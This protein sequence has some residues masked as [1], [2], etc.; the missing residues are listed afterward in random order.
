MNSSTL[1]D[2]TGLAAGTYTVT[3]TDVNG[4][5]A[6]VSQT[7]TAAAVLSV[8]VSSFT[9]IACNGGTTGTISITTTGGTTPYSYLWNNS[10]TLQDQTGLAVGT[11][12]V[13]V[14][15]V[16]GCTIT[17]S[18]IILSVSG[19]IIDL[20]ST[21]N[22]NC[23]GA[24]NGSI[25]ISV[26]GGTPPYLF[27]WSNGSSTEDITNIGVGLYLVT[28]S[29]IN[30]CTTTLQQ[31][32]S[33]PD[34]II[35]QLDTLINSPC[36]QVGSASIQIS[37]LGGT[38]PYSYLWSNGVTMQDIFSL[39]SGNYSVTVTDSIGCIQAV[40]YVV[41]QPPNLIGAITNV[42]NV[43]CNGQNNGSINVFVGGGAGGYTYNWSNGATN[44]NLTNVSAGTYT[45]SIKDVN[46]CSVTID[47][48][49]TEPLFLQIDLIN[50][51]DVTC[52]GGSNG[53]ITIQVSGGTSPY[54]YLW[55]NG[56]TTLSMTG[57][58]VGLYT[59]LVTDVNGC[60]KNFSESILQNDSLV[61]TFNST[62][63]I[64]NL[65]NGSIGVNVSG[66]TAPYTYLWSTGGTNDTVSNVPAGL[67][68]VSISDFDG[69]SKS[70]T[71]SLSNINGPSIVVDSINQ[72]LCNGP[73]NGSIYITCTSGT[74]PYTFLWSD[75]ST[76]EDLLNEQIGIYTVTV[77][78]AAGCISILTDSIQIDD[79]IEV[80]FNVTNAQCNL[81]NGSV[82]TSVTGGV[83][84]YGYLWSSGSTNSQLTN[85][86]AGTYTLT[87]TD[88]NGCIAIDSVQIGNA[89]SFSVQMNVIQNALCYGANT[90]AISC[91]P[92]GGVA[93]YS[94]LWSN[95]ITNQ[96]VVSLV[97][98]TYTV[99]VTDALGCTSSASETITEPTEIILSTSSINSLCGQANGSASVLAAGGVGPYQYNWSNGSTTNTTG[100]SG[101]GTYTVTVT[102]AINCSVSS[103]VVILNTNGP[104]ALVTGFTNNSCNS[105]SSGS[106][107][108]SV[109]G[110]APPYSVI[111]SNGTTT[112]N[113]NFIPSGTY[114]ATVTDTNNCSSVVVQTIIQ[115]DSINIVTS[116]NPAICTNDNGSITVSASG[117][118]G[119]LTFLWSTGASVQTLNGLS[120]GI[121]TVTVT[122]QN[123]CT[124]TTSI[125]VIYFPPPN[126]SIA[127]FTNISCYGFNN[128]VININVSSGTLPYTYLWSNGSTVANQ[129]NLAPGN[130]SVVVTDSLGCKDTATQFLTEPDSLYLLLA[131][132]NLTCGIQNGLVSVTAIGG[133]PLYTYLWSNNNTNA[134][135][136]GLAAGT[137]TVT[138]TDAKG[139][140]K[141]GS[142]TIVALSTPQLAVQ[143]QV[144][145]SCN[146]GNNGS[147]T[148]SVS[149]GQLAY[150]YLWST[151]G[152]T[153][154]LA[155]LIAGSYTVTV[156]DANGC[157]DTLIVNITQP[158]NLSVVL[159]KL[160]AICGSNNGQIT[161]S[162]SGGTTPYSFLWSNTAT[163][164]AINNLAAGTYTV[165]VTD[166]NGCTVISSVSLQQI[167][168]PVVTIQNIGSPSCNGG[169][170]GFININASGAGNLNFLW[171]NAA[172]TQNISLIT[173]GTYT[174]TVTDTNGCTSTL[175]QLIIEPALIDI[176]IAK[177]DVTCNAPN[178]VA[179]AS[180]S[181]G[182]GS[183]A[184]LWSNSNTT[185]TI[186]GLLPGVYTVTVTD[187]NLCSKT[188]SVTI[189]SLATPV[190]TFDSVKHV[191]C[192]GGSDGYASVFVTGGTSPYSYLW[193]NGST[194]SVANGLLAGLVLIT[195]TDAS[196]CSVYEDTLIIEPLPLSLGMNSTLVSCF[197][198]DGTASVNVSGGVSPYTYL[199]STGSTLNSI[200]GQ[201]TGTYTVTVTDGN[202]CLKSDT[203]NISKAP[204][205]VI[206]FNSVTGIGCTGNPVGAIDILVTGGI[207][208]TYLWSNAATTQD[209]SG[210]L[211]GLYTITVTNNYGCSS[212]D[213]IIVPGFYPISI[214]SNITNATC[215]N[216]NGSISSIVSGGS[217]AYFYLWS[218]NATTSAISGLP[219]GVYTVTVTDNQQCT[220]TTTFNLINLA[221]PG[222]VIDSI[223][224][225]LCAGDSNAAI[226]ISALGNGLLSYLWSNGNTLEDLIGVPAGTY[227]I[228]ISDSN[229]CQTDSTIIISQTLAMQIQFSVVPANCGLSNGA[230]SAAIING[231]QPYSYLWSTSSSSDTISSLSAGLFAL[232]VTDING[233]IISDTVSVPSLN[234]VL[235]IVDSIVQ[236]LCNGGSDGGVYL[237]VQSSSLFSY[238]W[239]GGATTEDLTGVAAGLYTLSITGPNGCSF[240][241]TFNIGQP[242]A[243]SA[244]FQL[245]ASA[246]SSAT[247]SATINVSGGT[248][249]YSYNWSNGATINSI[250]GVGSGTYTCTV[251][252]LNGCVFE[253]SI[254][255]GLLS[256][257]QVVT[258][259]I[260]N[261]KCYGESNGGIYI[262]ALNGIPLY[263][264]QW[265]NGA[266][267]Q[268]ITTL[269]A[270][271]YSVL[272]T[273][274]AGCK[275][276]AVFNITQP[277]S[278]SIALQ[279]VAPDCNTAN[280]SITAQSS[281]GT[282]G[283]TYLWD[284]GNTDAVLSNLAQGTYTVTV[285]DINGCSKSVSFN[286]F[287]V[288]APVIAVDSVIN[289]V[290]GGS[291]SGAIYITASGN[292]PFSYVWSNGSTL[293][294]LSGIAGGTYS[295]TVT[296]FAGCTSLI[297]ISV[298]ENPEIIL[299]P[300]SINAACGSS[301]GVAYVSAAGGITPY[302]YF[303]PFDN[304]TNDTLS[305]L[306]PGSYDVIIT[307]QL[308][309][310]KQTTVNVSNANAPVLSIDSIKHVSCAGGANGAIFVST[311]GG[312]QPYSYLWNNGNTNEDILNIPAGVYSLTIVDAL[313]CVMIISDTVFQPDS[314][315][316]SFTSTPAGCALPNGSATVIVNGGVPNY[317]YQWNVFSVT[318]SINGVP[319]GVYTVTITDNNLCT[320][321]ASVAIATTP[322]PIIS[323]DSVTDLTCFNAGD[324]GIDI[325]VSS[326]QQPYTF[327]W[328]NG[329]T[330]EDLTSIAA[331][332][333]TITVTDANNCT[334]VQQFNVNEPTEIQFTVQVQNSP[335]NTANGSASV[336]NLFGGQGPYTF[337][338][339]TSV[340]D[341]SS[342]VSG[343]FAG[344][345]IVTVTDAKNCSKTAIVNV[346]NTSGPAIQQDSIHMVTCIGGANAYI[347]VSVSG[348][349]PPFTTLWSNGSTNYTLSGLTA[350][351]YVLEVTDNAGCKTI[352]TVIITEPNA[353]VINSQ[354]AI[355]NPP[356][357]NISCNGAS[358]GSISISVSG[359][360]FPYNY[361]W[362]IGSTSSSVN[363]LAAGTY[364]VVV[365]DANNCTATVVFNLTEPP[366]LSSDAGSNIEI[367]GVDSVVLG[368]VNPS[369]G[370]GFWAIL[371]GGGN[372]GNVTS[373][374]SNVYN[375][376]QGI[377]TYL[378]IVADSS[379]CKDTSQVLVNV[380][381][382][383]TA[384]AGTDREICENEVL[385]NAT[386]PQFGFGAWIVSS[387]GAIVF[388]ST[389]STTQAFQLNQGNNSFQWI[390]VNGACV[391]TDEVNIFVK[392]SIDCLSPLEFPTGFSPN[393]DNFNEY[394]VIKGV[395]E[396]P[397]NILIVYNRWGNIVYE[398]KS[399]A[400]EWRG[401]NLD[402]DILPE[403][404][405]YVTIKIAGFKKYFTNFVDIRR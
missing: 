14:T 257:I 383:V 347:A 63:P 178:G 244:V 108:I 70:A 175:S 138:V 212:T 404:T 33:Q 249:A 345:Y 179:I 230:I 186:T 214:S 10:S 246:C 389:K 360:T 40:S 349:S 21:S 139:C 286:L 30:G 113:N 41:T 51:N 106:I 273:D 365:T 225:P 176:L 326:G 263:N 187:G 32:I 223:I 352:E 337:L 190:I 136:N 259:S 284:N 395:L 380:L 368:A 158:A 237:N 87:I 340:N 120:S 61:V 372:F 216:P 211:P 85:V 78:D 267:S 157:K 107:V 66:G 358:D 25:F 180:A 83:G 355:N 122:D 111:W 28:V 323:N 344:S 248:Q 197:G 82:L 374:T 137:Y 5:T 213:T 292:Q 150:S 50:K 24:L 91:T 53:S 55:S 59:L 312:T 165:T 319:P 75:G 251:T 234:K 86:F 397:D 135:Q 184:Y 283:Y 222:I 177:V 68:T 215:E 164:S 192:F 16:N 141:S 199:W 172:T 209:L 295:V 317:S 269:L 227:T 18:Q 306:L 293:D 302:S 336:I 60:T 288:G 325:T 314:I 188:A 36:F 146:G 174:V 39:L 253:D 42:S 1:Q 354:I 4:C 133:T 161:T 311:S 12:T 74:F 72:P 43:S 194:T 134:S 198:I 168:G 110:G 224:E 201:N 262:T 153:T 102:D 89:G 124:K 34:S 315:H 44:Q 37:V 296:D 258:D 145:V 57:L 220:T 398:K 38:P 207:S 123:S 169:S 233:C 290:C 300:G 242:A 144:N 65:S 71:V 116:V 125:S 31:L 115:P 271:N 152:T 373:N 321:S 100:P 309:C 64:C 384:I 67:Y 400:N 185:N 375:L 320:A 13:T 155:G 20:D 385:L 236:P 377:S 96:N 405:Y 363:G 364:T 217:G 254:V 95:A 121:Y 240:D 166:S 245:V 299:T 274:S 393:G 370:Y 160:N 219:A 148:V 235:F 275:D 7:L 9:N 270:G 226:Y 390:V 170:N 239:T 27:T 260:I 391:D 339:S 268:N 310:T 3:V 195:V 329:V 298:N 35:I 303:W 93:P 58:I 346:S 29:D 327:L 80:Q 204:D 243:L 351:S 401:T 47:T 387:G 203:V 191:S 362:S 318:Q 62:S 163:T 238:L 402:G 403:G 255:I 379:S 118:T 322:A 265:S 103:S 371:N 105:D 210:L 305:G 26:S 48:T 301:T 369:Y 232:T 264:Y 22:P 109:S 356:L 208:F 46:N 92:V 261:E 328:S 205:P 378:W 154:S 76:N 331:G 308:G 313:G 276:S 285:T 229:N 241:T 287:A 206:A 366:A 167:N 126:L 99:T 88:V 294:D 17:T 159:T 353:M 396:Y 281:G 333:Y 132:T 367:C 193:S 147:V 117:G 56:N 181:G 335:C 84:P 189:I 218:N 342:S 114:T 392:D 127:S 173:S 98:G 119:L 382:G 149:G 282:A 266:T 228:A 332:T 348:I 101:A 386:A 49:I 81:Q 129:S 90:G 221:S 350:G 11:Y 97:A 182:T 272:V 112:L 250:S 23:H 171:S 131:G 316:L 307:D 334:L 130:Y 359:G 143:S 8:A 304:S 279:S 330:S 278:I 361:L 156:T 45:L 399:Y 69:C 104:I 77:T 202:G 196:N 54:S 256:N 79:S 6:T 142:Q 73:N 247:G 297:Q 394:Y 52:Y 324:G 277:D 2:Q 376:P 291:N 19:V 280:G 162:V 140:T 151:G 94:F 381:D 231:S 15:D 341:T 128:G 357:Y 388:D 338:W 183:L 200:V 343:L 289:V 252:D